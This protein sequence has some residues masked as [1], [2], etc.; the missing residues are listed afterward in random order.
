MDGACKGVGAGICSSSGLFSAS[1][2]TALMALKSNPACLGSFGESGAA[3]SMDFLT[4]GE[5]SGIGLVAR[6]T[7]AGEPMGV[8]SRGGRSSSV[9]RVEAELDFLWCEAYDTADGGRDTFDVE[10]ASFFFRE[11]QLRFLG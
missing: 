6:D 11:N 7:G 9:D 2:R 3:G 1:P 8:A 5:T 4:S 10:G